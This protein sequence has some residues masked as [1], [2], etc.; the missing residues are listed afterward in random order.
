MSYQFSQAWEHSEG[1]HI[2]A[3]LTFACL[4]QSN[5]AKAKIL[6]SAHGIQFHRFSSSSTFKSFLPT[7]ENTSN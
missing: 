4:I 1:M 2:A 6:N 3:I 5:T 7:S